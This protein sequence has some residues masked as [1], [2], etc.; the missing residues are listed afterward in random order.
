MCNNIADGVMNNIHKVLKDEDINFTGNLD[1]SFYKTVENGFVVVKST[2]PYAVPVDRGMPAGTIVNFEALFKWVQ[3]KLG[4]SDPK[5]AMDVTIKI[6]NKII[7]KGIKPTRFVKK[8]IK[9]FIAKHGYI[10]P[11]INKS[12]TTKSSRFIK[13]V[14]KYVKK[15][16]KIIKKMNRALA[17]TSKFLNTVKRYRSEERRVG[18]ECRYM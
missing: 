8:A 10:R 6:R 16:N 3:G 2:S 12:K 17:K 7:T 14:L 9:M 4:I 18:K 15:A 1:R 13:K 11:Q 5:E